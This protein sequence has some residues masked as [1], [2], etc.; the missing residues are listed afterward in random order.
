MD[1]F[2][3]IRYFAEAAHRGSFSRAALELGISVP[4]VKKLV[5]QLE[6][7]L[8]VRLLVRS[9]QGLKPTA[10]G[11]RYLFDVERALAALDHADASVRPRSGEISGTVVISSATYL[12]ESIFAPC[13]AA[14]VERYPH[15][16]L[17]FRGFAVREDI[18][19]LG[20]DIYLTYGWF[21][22][23]DLVLKPLCAPSFVTV[24]TP[25]FWDRHGR[26]THPNEL[27]QLPCLTLRSFAGTLM[28]LWDYERD[29]EVL[30]VPVRGPATF[31]NAQRGTLMQLLRQSQGVFVTGD[32]LIRQQLDRGELEPVLTD[33][34]AVG[35]PPLQMHYRR[36]ARADPATSAVL[37]FIAAQFDGAP[38]GS[39]AGQDTPSTQPDW[40]AKRLPRAS[41]YL[42][43]GRTS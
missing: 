33:W 2:R 1:K 16:C 17:E 35:A 22:P 25:A 8:G 27:R 30:R 28:D 10:A 19:R 26:P 40:A 41:F 32:Y 3:A 9:S 43:K 13:F 42:D 15:I 4:A 11:A 29:G 34:K 21:A 14:F 23:E 18:A 38:S 36:D 6:Q 24:A 5:D 7:D 37:D 20:V 31:D 12:I 39:I